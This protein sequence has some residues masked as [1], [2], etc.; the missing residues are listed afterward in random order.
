VK[1]LNE[2]G[3]FTFDN[4]QKSTDVEAPQSKKRLLKDS[5]KQELKAVVVAK[6]KK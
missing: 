6:T 5:A 3:Y 4:G 1:E 2:K